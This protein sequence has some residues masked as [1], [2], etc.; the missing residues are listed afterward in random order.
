MPVLGARIALAGQRNIKEL[1]GGALVMN[2]PPT[3][4]RTSM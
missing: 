3:A 4:C 1:E 2:T